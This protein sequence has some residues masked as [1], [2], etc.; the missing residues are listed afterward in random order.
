[1]R[2]FFGLNTAFLGA[3]YQP[4]MDSFQ[5][6]EYSGNI[7]VLTERFVRTAHRQNV[8]I[9]V[10]TVDEVEDM[11]RMIDLGVDGLITNR[12]DLLLELLGR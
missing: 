9:D 10:W 11:E 4:R 6:P 3:V 1:M 7:H 2:L 12:P 8:R 5:I